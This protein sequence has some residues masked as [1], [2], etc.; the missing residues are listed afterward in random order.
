MKSTARVVACDRLRPRMSPGQQCAGQ[1]VSGSVKHMIHRRLPME[2]NAVTLRVVSG[3]AQQSVSKNAGNHRL[4]AAIP[5]VQ[6]P[7]HGFHLGEGRL[8]PVGCF[9]QNGRF[10]KVGDNDVRLAAQPAMSR[11]RVSV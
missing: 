1:H 6:R 2:E 7:Q 4:P 11:A 8:L 10:G 9:Q 5:L 3:G